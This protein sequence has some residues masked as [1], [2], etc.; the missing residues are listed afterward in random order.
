MTD[1]LVLVRATRRHLAAGLTLAALAAAM[2]APASAQTAAPGDATA[3]ATAPAEAG[4]RPRSPQ[5]PFEGFNRGV[6]SFNEGIDRAVLK[7]LAEGYRKVVPELVR[8]GVTNFFGNIADVW[9]G[10]NE[11]LQGKI[12]DGAQVTLRVATNTVF[13]LGGVL[14]PATEFGLEKRSEDFGQTLGRWGM[15]PGPYLMLP[16]F[17]PSTVRDTAA[18]PV[19]KAAGPTVLV[20]GTGEVAGVVVLQTVNTRSELLSASKLLDDVALDKYSF[21][22]DAYLARRRSQVYDGNP[23]EE[24]YDDGGSQDPTAPPPAAPAASAAAK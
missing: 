21:L 23:P 24:P 5:D 10:V 3:S 22:R 20:S 13:G 16:L 15:P 1:R 18:L 17:G 8:T 4:Q 14:D 6:Y 12:M 2:A 7:P 19:D 11:L 9:T